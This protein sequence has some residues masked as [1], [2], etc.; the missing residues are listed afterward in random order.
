MTEVTGRGRRRAPGGRRRERPDE[1]RRRPVLFMAV[2]GVAVVGATAFGLHAAAEDGS[3]PRP[4]GAPGDCRNGC[5]LPPVPVSPTG[6][7]EHPQAQTVSPSPSASPSVS[8]TTSAP[9][10]RTS[11]PGAG[12]K[13]KHLGRPD[14][15]GP[16][17]RTRTTG[18]EATY[19]TS[20]RW[21]SGFVGQITV[22]NTSEAT[23]NGWNLTASFPGARITWA[24]GTG[25]DHDVTRL[26][27]TGGPLAPGATVQL[28]FQ[29]EGR[30]PGSPSA[31]VLNGAPC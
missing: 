21:D 27:G 12:K 20:D 14:R 17:G 16:P 8:P 7:K 2:A 4:G 24:W 3:A 13:R 18:L 19:T 29:A 1:R 9:P 28:G 31:C 6:T 22:V 25:A 10:S 26:L 23:V 11:A 15:Q 30:P 5:A